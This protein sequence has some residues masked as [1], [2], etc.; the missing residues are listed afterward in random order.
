MN[1]SFP[2][3]GAIFPTAPAV[4]FRPVAPKGLGMAACPHTGITVPECS[5]RSCLQALLEQHAPD[6]AD[7]TETTEIESFR[8]RRFGARLRRLR[9]RR[10]A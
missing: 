10:V 7:Q 6:E 8:R 3:L 2:P 9:L 4:T 5:C 1:A